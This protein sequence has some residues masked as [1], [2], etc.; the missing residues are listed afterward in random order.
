VALVAAASCSGG[1]GDEEGAS[2]ST[3][4]TSPT[5]ITDVPA[6]A[7]TASD[8]RAILIPLE[9]LPTGWS[10]DPRQPEDVAVCGHRSLKEEL[11]TAAVAE[12]MFRS[13][14]G[15]EILAEGLAVF[16]DGAETAMV[17][18]RARYACESFDAGAELGE[19]S[20]APASFPQIGDDSFAFRLTANVNGIEVTYLQ[21]VWSRGPVVASIQQGGVAPDI[22]QLEDDVL[23]LDARIVD[24]L[25]R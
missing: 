21:V 7:L 19:V 17:A 22:E 3:A 11:P 20:I 15:S 25:D 2:P 9:D 16:V 10:E 14:D 12:A 4:S 1:N 6:P 23:T 13:G 5:S 18:A 24:R 8:L